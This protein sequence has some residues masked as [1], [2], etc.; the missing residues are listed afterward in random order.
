MCEYIRGYACVRVCLRMYVRVSY[1][2]SILVAVIKLMF[3]DVYAIFTLYL[4]FVGRIAHLSKCFVT[5]RR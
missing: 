1:H 2:M 3:Y 4:M 5:N